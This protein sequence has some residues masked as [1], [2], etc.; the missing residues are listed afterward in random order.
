MFP[1]VVARSGARF[2]P[3]VM[4]TLAGSVGHV[5]PAGGLPP[6]SVL[7]VVVCFIFFVLD[8]GGPPT[9]PEISPPPNTRLYNT[10]TTRALLV[11]WAYISLGCPA[12]LE[13]GQ[14]VEN[15][16]AGVPR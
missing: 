4:V 9:F 16:G 6:D 8:F 10:T 11:C 13:L 2:S 15:G 3:F 7:A 12:R 14:E 5:S 1:L